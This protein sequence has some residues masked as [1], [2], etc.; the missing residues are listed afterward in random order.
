MKGWMID[1]QK[2]RDSR[3]RPTKGW[4]GGGRHGWGWPQAGQKLPQWMRGELQGL[5]VAGFWSRTVDIPAG[6][7]PLAPSLVACT[8]LAFDP[9]GTGGAKSRCLGGA[10]VS[11]ERREVQC[12]RIQSSQRHCSQHQT[13][14]TGSLTAG[15]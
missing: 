3:E 6:Y 4:S 7:W 11:L 10:A 15:G 1:D 2:G 5:V 12:V 9:A 13:D 14:L 8:G